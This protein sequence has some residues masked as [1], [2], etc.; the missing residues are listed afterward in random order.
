MILDEL[1]VADRYYGLS[2]RLQAGFEFLRQTDLAALTIGRHS[3]AGDQLFA[4]V[5]DDQGRSE[6]GARLEAHRRYIDIQLAT[7]G[8]EIIGWRALAAC[9]S[10][11]EPYAEARDI[12]FF[13]DRPE[14]WLTLS[15]GLF[16]V[17][18]P[19]DAH[20]PLAGQGAVR[21]VVIKVAIF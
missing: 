13:G 2:P 6:T 15:A 12:A 8:V 7:A 5:S 18:F 16:A 9:R 11:A 20:A 21:K 14:T 10:I 17:F 19:D 3:I 1:T 4:L